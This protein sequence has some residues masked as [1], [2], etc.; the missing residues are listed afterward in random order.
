MRLAPPPPKARLPAT[1][2][3]KWGPVDGLPSYGEALKD[4]AS[5]QSPIELIDE[6]MDD[7]E[8]HRLY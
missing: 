6:A 1:Y 5:L 3:E 2:L 4:H 8:K 7:N